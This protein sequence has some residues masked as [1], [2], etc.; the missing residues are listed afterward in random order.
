LY[1]SCEP[2]SPVPLA[3]QSRSTSTQ[4]RLR[5]IRVRQRYFLR[6]MRRMVARLDAHLATV[7][8]QGMAA[9]EAIPA[10]NRLA[11]QWTRW[12]G[13]GTSSIPSP[14]YADGWAVGTGGVGLLAR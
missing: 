4:G 11:S 6:V 14:A 9:E 13:H 7:V 3:I 12:P 10:S 8:E 5:R 1:H 2:Q